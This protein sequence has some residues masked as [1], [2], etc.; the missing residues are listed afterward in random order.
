MDPV[1]GG[2]AWLSWFPGRL[3]ILPRLTFVCLSVGLSLHLRHLGSREGLGTGGIS[4]L[5]SL[6]ACRLVQSAEMVWRDLELGRLFLTLDDGC[7]G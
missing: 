5:L 6:G 1:G 4:C 2:G 3:Q 7:D